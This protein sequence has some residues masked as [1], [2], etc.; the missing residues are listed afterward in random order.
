MGVLTDFVVA[1]RAEAQ[2]VCDSPC[3]SRDFAGIDAKG[4]DTVKLGTLHAILDA[5]EGVSSF[6]DMILCDNGDDGPWVLEVPA[7]LVRRLAALD[8]ERLRSV[9]A[10][11]AATD[12]F[13]SRSGSWPTEDV[14]QTLEELAALCRRAV[15]EGK[16][17]LLWT[18]L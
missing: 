6:D 16:A 10:G 18:C 9:A 8:S 17:V 2:R 1:D 13:H 5:P 4:I 12:E 15:E 11:W 3:P 7:D 14:R